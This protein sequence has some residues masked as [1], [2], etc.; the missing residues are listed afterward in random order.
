MKVKLLDIIYRDIKGILVLKVVVKLF[1]SLGV[2][3]INVIF[4][5]IDFVYIGKKGLVV[6]VCFDVKFKFKGKM[7]LFVCIEKVK[8]DF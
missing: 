3:C 5:N 4:F 6:L 1:C 2:F 8:L 7:E